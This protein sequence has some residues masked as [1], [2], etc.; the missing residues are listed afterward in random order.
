VGT[1]VKPLRRILEFLLIYACG[2][3]GLLGIKA[4]FRLSDYLIPSAGELLTTA[5]ENGWRYTEAV[6]DTAVV[7]VAG[8]GFSILLAV[9]VAFV[10]ISRSFLGAL[11]KTAAYNLQAFPVVAIAP[12]LFIFLGDGITSRILVASLVCYFPLLLT[13]IGIFAQPVEDVEHFFSM[14]GRLTR[15][16]AL[17]IR[18]FENAGKILAVIAGS[19][20]MAMVGSIVAEFLVA[21]NGIGYVIRK[22]LYQSNLAHILV[23]LFFIGLFSSLYISIIELMGRAVQKRLDPV[24]D[25]PA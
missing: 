20:T 10:G 21:T 4:A 12:I 22:A 25:T 17:G 7:A 5:A 14:T 23:S 8:H 1:H 2:I 15:R 13:F 19:G 11:T 24:E 9:T 18:V 3:G 6:A 16:L